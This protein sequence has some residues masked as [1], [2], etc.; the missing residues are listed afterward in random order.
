MFSFIDLSTGNITAWLWDFGDGTSSTLQNPVHA[1]NSVGT[2][3][4]TLTVSGPNCT[5]SYSM[6]ITI[7]TPPCMASFFYTVDLSGQVYSFSDQSFGSPTSWLW[8]FGDGTTSTLQNPVH[9][10]TQNGSYT[11]TLTISGPNCSS[12]ETM[13]VLVGPPP[14]NA[15]FYFYPDS[16]NMQQFYFV[17]MSTGSP[18]SWS[19]DFGDGGTSSL[20]NPSHTYAQPGSY[21]VT[22]TISGPTCVDSQTILITIGTLPCYAS[23]TFTTTPGSMLAFMFT[24]TS[25]GNPSSWL[26]DFGDGTTSTSQNPIHTYSQSGTY[27]VTLVISGINCTSTSTAIVTAGSVFCNADFMFY[28]DST[29]LPGYSFIDLSTGN[30]TGWLWDFGDGSTST[31][32]NPTHVYN[33]GGTFL[34]TLTVSGPNCSDSFTLTITV[35]TPPC[36]AAFNYTVDLLTGQIYSFIDLSTGSPSSWLWDFGDGTTST[37]QNPMHTYAQNGTYTVI[38]TISGPNCT[39]TTTQLIVV[40]PA[41]CDADFIFY[42]DSVNLLQFYFMDLSTGSPTSWMWNFGDGT[43]STNQ[44]PTHT[45]ALAGTYTVTLSIFGPGCQDVEFM[46][47]TAGSNVLTAAFSYTANPALAYT[48]LFQDMS[49]GNPIGW[50]W[51]FGD[52]GLSTDQN[53]SYSYTQPGTYVV[54]LGIVGAGTTS[55]YTD[56]IVVALA[57][58]CIAQFSYTSSPVNPLILSFFD[59]SIGIP[60]AFVWDFGDGSSSTEQNPVHEYTTGGSYTVSMTATNVLGSDMIT[61]TVVV[62]GVNENIMLENQEQFQI[63]PNPNNGLFDLRISNPESDMQVHITNVQGQLIQT[64]TL[65][66][67]SGSESNIRIDLTPYSK[68]LYFVRLS[69]TDLNYYGKVIVR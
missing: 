26:W 27:I 29:G 6:T 1:Y 65:S 64:E 55:S 28:P 40:G 52:G 51:D 43:T 37:M 33:S 67:E 20:Q 48:Y 3:V 4:V 9:T 31:L 44:N 18:S 17:D 8:N 2:F 59:Q 10:Y 53:P 23:F 46:T 63:V 13:T 41:S 21:S 61:E 15:D 50:L 38:L 30:I 69:G 62:N 16:F 36:Q 39:S 68:G 5:D 45:Y 56:T 42:T 49:T 58:T 32:Q 54:T 34:V 19:W 60:F 14:C 66:N 7:G 12:T 47:V 57:Q 35:G 22:L 25:V 11:V 24:D